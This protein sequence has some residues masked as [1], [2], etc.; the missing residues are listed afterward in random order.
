MKM[1]RVLL[2][3][4]QITSL[5]V[6]AFGNTDLRLGNRV[7]VVCPG[8]ADRNVPDVFQ[9]PQVTL[10][11][12][13]GVID[14]NQTLRFEPNVSSNPRRGE[15]FCQT[16]ESLIVVDS[17]GIGM[18]IADLDQNATAVRI[19]L[20]GADTTSKGEGVSVLSSVCNYLVG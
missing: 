7:G 11:S 15:F 18:T 4:F 6:A 19:R 9:Q 3:L 1:F 10:Q 20:L 16:R 5:L 8:T 14:P 17:S 13:A 2:V 12:Q